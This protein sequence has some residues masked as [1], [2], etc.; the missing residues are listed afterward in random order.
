M[1]CYNIHGGMK[2]SISYISCFD[3]VTEG[4]FLLNSK[5][6]VLRRENPK[7]IL[8]VKIME[9]RQFIDDFGLNI[10]ADPSRVGKMKVYF[11]FICSMPI[12]SPE[13]THI[14]IRNL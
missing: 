14:E 3:T 7:S 12:H 13:H 8:T 9:W 5:I 2:V 1:W 6:V 10:E 11:V 4:C